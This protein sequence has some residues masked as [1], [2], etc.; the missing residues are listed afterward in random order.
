MPSSDTCKGSRYEGRE[1]RRWRRRLREGS[2][3]GEERHTAEEKNRG[4]IQSLWL[5]SIRTSRLARIEGERGERR[6]SGE[7]RETL[8]RDGGVAA[9]E[10]LQAAAG[11][12]RAQRRV[13]DLR[14]VVQT[15]VRQRRQPRKVC[16]ACISDLAPSQVEDAELVHRSEADEAGVGDVRPC[17]LQLLEI[18]VSWAD[19][20]RRCAGADA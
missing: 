15:N 5:V 8:V 4:P 18:S 19:W 12:E 13:A 7:G 17:E 10:A 14:A 16:D 1:R 20:G 3:G 9:V 2:G 6:Q 11:G